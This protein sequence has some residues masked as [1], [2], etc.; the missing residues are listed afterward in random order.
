MSFLNRHY[1]DWQYFEFKFLYVQR[2]EQPVLITGMDFLCLPFH[3]RK[4]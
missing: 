3:I 1:Q 2:K 4:S